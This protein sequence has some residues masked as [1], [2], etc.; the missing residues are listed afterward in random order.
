MTV[1][2]TVSNTGAGSLPFHQHRWSVRAGARD[3]RVV[4]E[5]L[6]SDTIVSIDFTI[7]RGAVVVVRILAVGAEGMIRRFVAAG[8]A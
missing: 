7:S 5:L 1:D 2:R 8:S 6:T 4:V 3:Y